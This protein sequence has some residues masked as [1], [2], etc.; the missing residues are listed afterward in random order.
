MGCGCG[1]KKLPSNA[2]PSTAAVTPKRPTRGPALWNG[3]TPKKT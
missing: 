3:P 2:K 1:G